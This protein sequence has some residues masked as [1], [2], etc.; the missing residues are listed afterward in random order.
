MSPQIRLNF[1]KYFFIIFFLIIILFFFFFSL[2][3][4]HP[5]K[6][7]DELSETAYKP[8]QT[9]QPINKCEQMTCTKSFMFSGVTCPPT[10][11]IADDNFT[12]SVIDGDN[13]KPYPS[14]CPALQCKD[15]N[16]K[17]ITF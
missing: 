13:T 12:C 15:N 8:G 10:P 4:D 11:Q 14:C 7:W 6:C 3:L 17:V 2:I 1:K 9:F 16:G 5:G